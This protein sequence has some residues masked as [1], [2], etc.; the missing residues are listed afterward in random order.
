MK[1]PERL[2]LDPTTPRTHKP[3]TYRLEPLQRIQ[4]EEH[5]RPDNDSVYVPITDN[6]ITNYY[7]NSQESTET[8]L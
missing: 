3:K 5:Y 7:E 2:P 1:E 6:H 4:S 8:E